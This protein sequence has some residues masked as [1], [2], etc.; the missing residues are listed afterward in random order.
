MSIGEIIAWVAVLLLALYGCAQLIRRLCLWATRCSG[1]AVCCRLAVPREEAALVPLLQCLESQ[2]VWEESAQCR[3]TLVLLPKGM[4]P[5]APE[6]QTVLE[7]TPSVILVTQEQLV[8]TMQQ[9][10]ESAHKI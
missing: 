3:Q 5:Q 8:Q 9:L 4:D 7:Q 10:Q 6:L 1:C 2:A